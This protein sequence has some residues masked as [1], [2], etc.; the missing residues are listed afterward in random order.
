M[1][2]KTI[3]TFL[4]LLLVMTSCQKSNYKCTC[5][6]NNWPSPNTKTEITIHDTQ[7]KAKKQC[8]SNN[9]KPSG[10]YIGAT[11]HCELN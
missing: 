11:H 1:T 9:P 6:Y 2:M 7:R 4:I 8:D 10:G 5:T 3:F